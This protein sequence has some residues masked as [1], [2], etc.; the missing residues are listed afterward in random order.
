MRTKG[1][2]TFWNEEKGFGFITPIAGGKQVFVHIKAFSNRNRRPEVN[3]VVTYTLSSDKQGR[4]CAAKATLAGDRLPQEK[5]QMNGSLSLI[6]A[7]FFV[8]I[9][10]V[11]VVASKIPPL[12]LAT[13]MAASLLTFIMYAIDKSAAKNGSWRT[14]ESTLHLLS[15]AGGWPGAIVAQQKLRHKS[16]KQSFRSMFWVTVFLNCGAFVW[17]LTPTGAAALQALIASIV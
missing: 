11:T 1:K 16:K 13:Y 3:E 7:A 12:I 14:P 17:L 10:G 9:V 4:P 5:N 2:I 6:G 8:V 15:L